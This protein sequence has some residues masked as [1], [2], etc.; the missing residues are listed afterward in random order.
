MKKLIYLIII[1]VFCHSFITAKTVNYQLIPSLSQLSFKVK[2]LVFLSLEAHCYD[3]QGEIKLNFDNML[4]SKLTGTAKVN[5]ISTGK[6]I[7]DSKLYSSRFLAAQS[8]PIITFESVEI[9]KN[10]QNKYTVRGFLTAKG[11]T[12]PIKEDLS[13][14][15]LE[16][17]QII[18]SA[19][20]S[21]NRK[22]FNIA[23]TIPSVL[24]DDLIKVS[25]KFVVEE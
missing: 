7:I 9:T 24:I 8:Y 12:A 17:G 25:I 5:S 21:L 16:E 2:Y 20:L 4:H 18:L 14:I 23:P 15:E 11:I 10:H 1:L 6:H 13:I 22:Q 19:N 3:F